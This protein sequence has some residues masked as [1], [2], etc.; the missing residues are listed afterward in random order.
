MRAWANSIRVLRGL[1]HK[2]QGHR[3]SQ[4]IEIGDSH[5]NS[6]IFWKALTRCE[7]ADSENLGIS[8]TVP[9]IGRIRCERW[10]CSFCCRW[11]SWARPETPPHEEDW[12]STGAMSRAGR[13]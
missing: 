5:R 13:Q 10:F 8:V 1:C 3:N 12:I 4:I 7:Y 2:N 6:E 9:E 11:D